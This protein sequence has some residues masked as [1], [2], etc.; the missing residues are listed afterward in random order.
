M[1]DLRTELR[2]MHERLG[3]ILRELDGAP[4]QST[5][6]RD[7]RFDPS[8]RAHRMAAETIFDRLEITEKRRGWFYNKRFHGI[9]VS[10]LEAII[11]AEDAEFR[12]MYPRAQGRNRR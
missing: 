4:Q 2:A 12:R 11:E 10:E 8:N 7:E 1:T 6:P 5:A 3:R 9:R